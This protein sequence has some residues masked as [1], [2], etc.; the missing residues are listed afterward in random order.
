[1]PSRFESGER[2]SYHYHENPEDKYK[3]VYYEAFDRV[4]ACIRERFEQKDY[5]MYA[6]MQE[7]LLSAVH[8]QEC[9]EDTVNCVHSFYGDDFCKARLKD[10]LVSCQQ[11]P[12][13]MTITY[14]T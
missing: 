7:I 4:I 14:Q 8:K 13:I 6:K 1:M 12:Q 11:W 5:Q 2:E 3:K 9:S 10:R